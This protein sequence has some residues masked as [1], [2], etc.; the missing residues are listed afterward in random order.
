MG[1]DSTTTTSFA[2]GNV[3]GGV[4]RCFH[5]RLGLQSG[6]RSSSLC[7]D[8]NRLLGRRLLLGVGRVLLSTCASLLAV[9]R[10][11]WALLGTFLG[12]TTSTALV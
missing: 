2:L 4:C 8:R 12:R 9:S 5:L 6:S 3:G 1:K 7:L 10:L 11:S